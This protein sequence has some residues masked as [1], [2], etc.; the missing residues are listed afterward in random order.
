MTRDEF[1]LDHWIPALRSGDYMQGQE[2][3]RPTPNTYCCLGVACD[4]YMKLVDDQTEW[5]EDGKSGMFV[6]ISEV[7]K[8]DT[9]LP[10]DIRRFLKVPYSG[11][12]ILVD[13]EEISVAEANDNG[14]PFAKL[15]DALE[16]SFKEGNW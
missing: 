1:I 13:G 5:D 15:A 7:D 8:A 10:I 16:A 2:Y 6:Y 4:L 12:K 11:P 9:N 3:L 14:V